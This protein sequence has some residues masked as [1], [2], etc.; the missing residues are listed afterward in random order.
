M[1]DEIMLKLEHVVKSF[2]GVKA[3]DDVS[4]EVKK[5][6]IHALLG[7]N[8]A[9]KSTL[10]KIISGA[11]VKD[12]GTVTLDSEEINLTSPQAGIKKGIGMVYQELDLIPDLSGDE[13]IFLGQNKFRNRFGLIDAQSRR[14]EAER[15]IQNFD[16]DIDLSLPVR[17]LGV[18]KQQVIAIAKAISREA[19]VVIFDEPTA[20]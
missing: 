6:E 17:K 2:P 15:I 9:G 16:I 4:L 20:A 18:S 19:K 14:R 13:N 10:V 7:H 3:V 1:Q 8:G 12:S 11:Y 5:G